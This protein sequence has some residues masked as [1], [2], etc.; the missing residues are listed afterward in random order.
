MASERADDDRNQHHNRAVAEREER[1]AITRPR[2]A[3][4]L[5]DTREPVDGREVVGVEAVLHAE[6]EDEQAQ[7]LGVL[8][9][10]RNR[11]ATIHL[12]DAARVRCVRTI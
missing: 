10:H 5:V 12:R 11:S 1:A 9:Q 3:S 8:R 7:R 6:H 4:A 2:A